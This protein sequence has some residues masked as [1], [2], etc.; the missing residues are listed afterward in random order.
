MIEVSPLAA[1]PRFEPDEGWVPADERRFGLD[2]RTLR[3]TLAVFGL[4][5]VMSVVLPVINGTVPYHDIVRPGD[6]M[7]IEGDVTFVPEAGWGVTSG[8]RA[9]HA[10]ISGQ[11]PSSATVEDGALKFTLRTGPFHGDADQLVDQIEATSDALH[12]GR[13]VHITGAPATIMTAAGKQGATVRVTGPH[14]AGLIAA[15]VFDGRGVEAV[16]TG[17]TDAGP[18][19]SA[20]VLRM[21]GS[22]NE[23]KQAQR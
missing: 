5:F 15:F 2:R 9:G 23:S 10:P 1:A 6:V 8:V 11:Y 14:T 22:I 3:P 17:P 7:Q 21:I 16:A 4:V 19:P 13:G 20:A 18:E 12:Q